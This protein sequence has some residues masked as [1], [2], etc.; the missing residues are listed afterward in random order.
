MSGMLTRGEFEYDVQ[1]CNECQGLLAHDE[2]MR[3][4]IEEL[5]KAITSI[6]SFAEGAEVS[7]G[8]DSPWTAKTARKALEAE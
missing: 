7:G 2:A 6:A 4:R 1:G 8:F 3:A 5:E